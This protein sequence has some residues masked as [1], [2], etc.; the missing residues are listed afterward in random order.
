MKNILARTKNCINAFN[1]FSLINDGIGKDRAIARFLAILYK[2]I[3]TKTGIKEINKITNIL[4][5]TKKLTLISFLQVAYKPGSVKDN[6]LMAI[7]LV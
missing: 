7:Y 4:T 2:K 6:L 3:Y 5:I 1:R